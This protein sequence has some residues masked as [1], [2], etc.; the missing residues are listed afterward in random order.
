[1]RESDHFYSE[2]VL[3]AR[4][5]RGSPAAAIEEASLAFSHLVSSIVGTDIADELFGWWQQRYAGGESPQWEKLG[6]MAAFTLGDYDV[7]TMDL[8]KDDWEAI[9]DILS[10]AADEL[11]L[12]VLS[13][14]MADL[15]SHGALD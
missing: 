15:V 4:R 5:N 11:D 8:D 12:D 2:L 14:L 7:A 10:D 6:H 9:R 1:M 3:A 13:R